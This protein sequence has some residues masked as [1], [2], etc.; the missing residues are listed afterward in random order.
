M[1]PDS[2]VCVDSNANILLAEFGVDGQN[3]GVTHEGERQD[4]DGV[5]RLKRQG[6]V[7]YKSEHDPSEHGEYHIDL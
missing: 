3:F 2:R 4:G 6:H 7:M 5:R 1:F